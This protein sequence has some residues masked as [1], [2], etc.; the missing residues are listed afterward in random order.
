MKLSGNLNCHSYYSNLASKGITRHSIMFS[1]LCENNS[2]RRINRVLKAICE[3]FK[4]YWA[5][6]DVRLNFSRL[7]ELIKF[8]WN[9]GI[10]IE[11]RPRYVI[12][13]HFEILKRS[14]VKRKTALNAYT[15]TY[16][17]HMTHN[18]I[19]TYIAT[20]KSARRCECNSADMN[21][22]RK[23]FPCTAFYEKK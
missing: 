14:V 23:L 5:L 20:Y 12:L 9:P 3:T 16:T 2:P 11:R 8:K 10:N 15:F 21:S 19:C 17:Y 4:I 18:I 7:V 13:R 6:C 22:D 1:C